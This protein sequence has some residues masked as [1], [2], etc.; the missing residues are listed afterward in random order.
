MKRVQLTNLESGEKF[1]FNNRTYTVH[2]HEGN[3]TEVFDGK[4]F[5]AWPRYSIVEKLYFNNYY[6]NSRTNSRG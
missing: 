3:M 5:W 2:H 1:R 4:R 6:E